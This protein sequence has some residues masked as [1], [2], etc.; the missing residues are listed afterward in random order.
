[1]LCFPNAKINIGL[2]I[3]EK[4]ADGFHNL[5]TLFYPI[6]LSDILEFTIN[7][8]QAKSIKF[9]NTGITID[10]DYQTNLI[11]KACKL[12]T[13]KE[14]YDKLNIHL[15]KII[16]IG[17]GLGGGSSDGAFMVK[18][19]NEC[20]NL[21]LTKNKLQNFSQQLG[22]DCAFFIENKPSLAYEKGT[23]IKPINLS[24]KGF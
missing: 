17:A 22:S 8:N 21:G 11:V 15:H 12:L 16:P 23:K 3:I 20:F 14:Q 6:G 24:L 13:E 9:S 2:N 4:R 10:G 7:D 19:L 1:M 5:E 18:S